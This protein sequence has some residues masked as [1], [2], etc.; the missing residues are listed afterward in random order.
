ML[1]F[2]IKLFL[3]IILK[4]FIENINEISTTLDIKISNR[5]KDV[6]G[7]CAHKLLGGARKSYGMNT[8][9]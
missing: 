5:S 1:N 4:Y 8:R 3:K 6:A 9:V 2:T 7:G